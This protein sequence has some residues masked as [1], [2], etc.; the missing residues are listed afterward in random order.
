MI[1]FLLT[2]NKPGTGSYRL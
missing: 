2:S 1:Q